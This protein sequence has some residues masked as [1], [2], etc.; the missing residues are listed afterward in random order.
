MVHVSELAVR[1]TLGAQVEPRR[2]RSRLRCVRFEGL[3]QTKHTR[4]R[5]RRAQL[6]LRVRAV[7]DGAKELELRAHDQGVR[8]RGGRRDAVRRHALP[9][10]AHR[11]IDEGLLVGGT[12]PIVEVMLCLAFGW[13]VARR[14]GLH[15]VVTYLEGQVPLFTPCI[16]SHQQGTEPHALMTLASKTFPQ[17]ALAGA[18]ALPGLCLALLPAVAA[19]LRL[20]LPPK[21]VAGATR[22]RR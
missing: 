6:C 10:R 18:S 14:E 8:C 11:S 15:H 5:T 3:L 12:G 9:I 17:P 19:A 4:R 16:S 13:W 22:S 21:V 20:L 7:P 2:A 1:A